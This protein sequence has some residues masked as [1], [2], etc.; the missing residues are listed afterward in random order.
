MINPNNN[1]L[2]I[3]HKDIDLSRKDMDFISNSYLFIERKMN[4]SLLFDIIYQM[5]QIF[6]FS[7]KVLTS[8]I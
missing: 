5:K 7:L 6:L 4:L 8:I 2:I 1:E 3:S